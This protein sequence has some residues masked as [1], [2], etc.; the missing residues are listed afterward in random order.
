MTHTKLF[1]AAAEAVTVHALKHLR[2]MG[3]GEST[4][5]KLATAV[6]GETFE[7]KTVHPE[8]WRCAPSFGGFLRRVLTRWRRAS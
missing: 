1:R 7:F 5:A 4:I 2:V 3:E 6:S 8:F